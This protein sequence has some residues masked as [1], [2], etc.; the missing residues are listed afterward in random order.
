MIVAT[1]KVPKKTGRPR[2]VVDWKLLDELCALQCTA[3]E[4]AG[5]LG[6]APDILADKIKERTGLFFPEYFAQKS[7]A[8]KRSLRRRQ[9]QVALGQ[10]IVYDKDGNVIQQP[11]APSPVMLIWLGKQYLQQADKGELSGKDGVPLR[12]QYEVVDI[13][14]NG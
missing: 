3:V 5:V 14:G 12:I 11:I 8:G 9:F 7:A 6:M 2:K 1:K 4:I 13:D 10:E